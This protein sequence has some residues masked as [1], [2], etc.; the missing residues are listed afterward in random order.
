MEKLFLVVLAFYI[1]TGIK[2]LLCH[3]YKHIL[4]A[5]SEVSL[6]RHFY[7]RDADPLLVCNDGTTGGYY[8]R[9]ATSLHHSDKVQK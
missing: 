6:T 8:F 9:E 1:W 2:A 4:S 5:R 3:P 7:D